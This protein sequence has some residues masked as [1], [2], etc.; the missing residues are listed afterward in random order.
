MENDEIYDR[1]LSSGDQ[2]VSRIFTIVGSDMLVDMRA[3]F[4]MVL[5]KIRVKIG[6]SPA[7]A[8]VAPETE[9]A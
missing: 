3:Q 6:W 9:T 1:L 2:G 7:R 4:S 5:V 8:C